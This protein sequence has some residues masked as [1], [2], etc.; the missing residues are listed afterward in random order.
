MRVKCFLPAVLLALCLLP[1]PKS[2][3]QDYQQQAGELSTLY[4]G[5]IPNPYTIRYNG[6]FYV[7]TRRYGR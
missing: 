6:T 1:A 5:R 7:E 3:G 2:W 4:R